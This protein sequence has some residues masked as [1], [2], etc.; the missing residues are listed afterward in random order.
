MHGKAAE[1]PRNETLRYNLTFDDTSKGQGYDRYGNMTCVYDS[2]T[3]G[4]TTSNQ[5]INS[6]YTYDA[7]GN[8]TKDSSNATAHTYQWD[9][10][11]RVASVDG[12]TTWSFTYNAVG[13]RVAWVSGGVTY[14]HLFDPAGNWLGVAGSYSIIMQGGRP[15][16]V[17]NSAETWFHHVN[18]IDSRTFMTNHYGTPTQD[19]LFY[20]YGNLWQSWGGGGL[21]FADLP[22]RD[23]NTTTD[24]TTYRLFSP[25]IGRWH[26]PDPLGGDITNPQSLNRYAYV[27]N[28][29]TT[30]TD[31]MGL[32]N[33]CANGPSST[34]TP[35]QNAQSN[36]GG[37]GGGGDISWTLDD[38]PIT[39]WEASGLLASGAAC[40][41]SC[42]QPVLTL[43]N[44]GV[45]NIVQV[46]GGA[47]YTDT[48]GEETGPSEFG[49]PPLNGLF[50]FGGSLP[51]NLPLGT[52]TAYWKPFKQGFK[53]AL[54][55]L[56][57]PGCSDFF[58]GQ[59]SATMQA[60]EYRF[61]NLGSA[62]VGA[63]T[64]S[65]TNVFI[66]SAG[67]FM[68]FTSGSQAFGMSWNVSQFRALILLRELGHQLSGITGF[69]PDANSSLNEAQS[70]QVIGSCF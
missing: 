7:A 66:N 28:N 2:T 57:N 6:G 32:Q 58:G 64:V 50:L 44:G 53:A 19:M 43:R 47:V 9:A 21:E 18:N 49:L 48:H 62:A 60:T 37:G 61:L 17:Y 38:S 5:I 59:G 15:L 41:G 20:P 23:P 34:C 54:K 67:P 35:E 39:S 12:G 68:T 10:E 4:F 13:N 69:Q 14:D 24:L 22:Y 63:E 46:A 26:S 40:I 70:N 45:I 52:S 31:P 1:S 55:D 11:G 27:L 16:V 33:P 56:K 3:C 29:P 30:L 65:P 36:Q 25:N 8:L 51:G 42:S